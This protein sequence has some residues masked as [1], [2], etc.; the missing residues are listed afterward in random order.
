M[1]SERNDLLGE[2]CKTT[3][4]KEVLGEVEEGRQGCIILWEKIRLPQFASRGGNRTEEAT[5]REISAL[6][7]E[8]PVERQY[9]VWLRTWLWSPTSR[10]QTQTSPTF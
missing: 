5:G 8:L 2:I 3:S 1:H 6:F 4:Y 9:G 7:K 10:L